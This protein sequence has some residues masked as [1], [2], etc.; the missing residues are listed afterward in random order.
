VK[1]PLKPAATRH[2]KKSTAPQSTGNTYKILQRLIDSSDTPIFSV[3][4]DYC[5]TSFNKRHGS[6]MKSLYGVEIQLGKS[7]LSYMTVKED[8]EEARKNLDAA[9]LKGE[10]VTE[11]A[12]S[13]DELLSRR[14]FEVSHS[15][16]ID[17]AG[18]VDGVFV[19]ARDITRQ[20]K[21]EEAV[22]ESERRFKSIV[23]HV[24]DIFY[25][26]DSNHEQLYISQQVE[27]ALGYTKEEVRT[28]WRTY[29]TDNPLNLSGHEKTQLAFT[30]GE[31]QE[32]YL[33]EF[34]HKDGTTRL[35]EINESPLKND[36]GEVIGI[37][38]AARD[39]T[40]RKRIESA[41]SESEE[42]YRMVVENA[43][44]TIVIA[45][46]GFNRF[47][48]RKIIELTGYSPEEITTKPF[49]EFVHPDDRQMVAERYRQRL[50]GED[51]PDIYA[52]RIV[53][54]SG[55]I[56]WVELSAASITWEGR[57]AT[58]NFV[59]DVTARKRLEEEEQRVSKLE[60][61]GVLA[62]GI[63]HDFNNILTAILG[64][65]S[66]A[67]MEAGPD[68]EILESLEQ[69]EKASLRAK[70]LTQ[71]LLTFSKG[72]A[73]VKKLKSLRE[74]LRDTAGFALRGSNVKCR[75]SIPA[76]LWHAEID[77]GQI[78]QAIHNMVLNAQQA[79]PGGGDIELR[80]ENMALTEKLSLGKGLPLKEGNYLRI[81][82]T[83]H[84]NG[85]PEEYLDKIF[86]PFFTTKHT[87]SGLGLATS[88]SIARNHGGHLS[89]ES[90]IGS[91]STFYL[92]LPASSETAAPKRDK[93]EEIRPVA[94]AKILV[95]DDEQGVREVA[96]RILKH[97]GYED[98]E[99]AANGAEAVSLYKAAMESGQPF[100]V[101]ILD[102]TIAG[103][104]GGREAIKRL[105]DVDPGVKA[106]V[107][108]G[109]TD[110]SVM[111]EYKEYGFSGMI[112]KPYTLKELGKAVRDVIS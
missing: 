5:Y 59:T 85:I 109:Y 12:Y 87:G 20:R 90:E 89:V 82:V 29:L 6:V 77:A 96:G 73:P 47:A 95:M 25:I 78:S 103:G 104:M 70:E 40:E 102:L 36:K 13:G 23:E 83:D 110:Q 4:R 72:G 88:F 84:G 66:L 64:N 81:A 50:K 2:N 31:K 61:V 60:S 58:L 94:G 8:R 69:A 34:M 56:K 80:A 74:L 91:G 76:D 18:D 45:A 98:I 11:E 51:I 19:I 93:K 107:C 26:L 32:P 101:V 49:I 92:Y 57:P 53:G 30:T 39:I 33:L 35:A 97:I 106:I 28:N 48:N 21:A 22:R 3:A 14:Y 86:D 99:F 100:S 63:A 75:Y 105:L 67:R 62:G 37:V 1:K 38:G 52:F 46:D 55:H 54:K 27:Q 44:E 15:P 16:I 68:S 17:P 71:Q 79:M 108:S 7:L 112:T 9:L 111:A 24:T 41:L 43:Q 10:T 65:I 42:K